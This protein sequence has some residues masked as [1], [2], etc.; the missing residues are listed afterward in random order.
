M[1]RCLWLHTQPGVLKCVLTCLHAQRVRRVELDCLAHGLL[2]IPPHTSGALRAKIPLRALQTGFPHLIFGFVFETFMAL[3]NRPLRSSSAQYSTVSFDHILVNRSSH[4]RFQLQYRYRCDILGKKCF[5]QR[6]RA[7][8]RYFLS[9]VDLHIG[10]VGLVGRER[11]N[12]G[13]WS[14]GRMRL[15][16]RLRKEA[17]WPIRVSQ[18]AC[19][20]GSSLNEWEER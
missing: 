5:R 18:A 9:G 2:V 17:T 20:L 8:Y 14:V 4:H 15:V 7:L 3:S 1:Q 10:V 6:K 13:E 16:L 19:P 11:E 12:G